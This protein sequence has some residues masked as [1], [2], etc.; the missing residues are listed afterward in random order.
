MMAATPPAPDPGAATGRK[1]WWNSWKVR[2]AWMAATFPLCAIVYWIGTGHLIPMPLIYAAMG[3]F[4]LLGG[5]EQGADW[6]KLHHAGKREA[7]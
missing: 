2:C 4:I 7:V 3:P 5:G 6:V 1:P